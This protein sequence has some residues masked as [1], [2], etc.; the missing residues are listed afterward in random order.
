MPR[1]LVKTADSK[2]NPLITHDEWLAYRRTGIGGSDAGTVCGL[3]PYTSK[4]ELWADKTGRLPSK[5]DNEN[6]RLGRYLE[7]YVAMR[8]CEETGKKVHRRNMIFQHD[9]H[10]FILANVDRE[11]NGE[12]AGLECKTTTSFNRSDFANGEIPLYF[13]CQCVHYMNVMKYDK[14]YIAILLKDIGQFYWREIFY[15]K[16]ESEALIGL[17]IDFWNSHIIPDV[18]PEPDGSESAKDVLDRLFAEREANTVTLFEQ[19][20]TAAELVR[21][22]AELKAM[23]SEEKRLKQTL[24][25]ALENNSRGLTEHYEIAYS[26]RS[27]TRVDSKLLRQK[28]PEIYAAVCRESSANYFTIKERRS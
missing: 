24:I 3:H 25:N 2:G 4:I 9:E 11:V 23:E 5:E 12:N 6:M 19:E 14:M 20:K 22:Q 15:D 17:E 8:F 18:R 27:S 1:I 16:D 7:D 10:D 28:Y 21:V 26:A 13:H